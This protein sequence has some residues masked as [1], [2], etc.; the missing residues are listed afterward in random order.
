MGL[1]SVG[2]AN[3][4]YSRLPTSRCSLRLILI[5]YTLP[6]P[7]TDFTTFNTRV[8][9]NLFFHCLDRK[10]WRRLMWGPIVSE[11]KASKNKTPVR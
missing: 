5:K 8:T 7:N 1:A 2:T 10:V 4:R 6:P 11:A 9:T 3:M